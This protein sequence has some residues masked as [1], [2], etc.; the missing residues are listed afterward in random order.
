MFKKIR[1]A[2]KL[3]KSVRQN[4]KAGLSYEEALQASANDMLDDMFGDTELSERKVPIPE[5]AEAYFEEESR[6]YFWAL[7]DAEPEALTQSHLDLY[8]LTRLD[9]NGAEAGAACVDS[10]APFGDLSP[11][12]LMAEKFGSDTVIEQTEAYIRF[13]FS[14][15]KFFETVKIEPGL[16]PLEN[17]TADDIRQKFSG[18]DLDP[19]ETSLGLTEDGRVNVTQEMIAIL[20]QTTWDWSL[21]A[22]EDFGA[23]PGAAVDPKRPYGNMT[24]WEVEMAQMLGLSLKK[25]DEG[26]FEVSEEQGAQLFGYH[27]GQLACAQ[28][29]LEHGSLP[30]PS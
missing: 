30:D 15:S 18:Y 14:F 29:I 13:A 23:W 22:F 27:L 1:S 20:R 5:Q 4:Q 19:S 12:D 28:A 6:D 2:F 10:A 25:N 21:H 11:L 24:N 3:Y 8:R 16:Y 17:L 9:W 26:Y 7:Y